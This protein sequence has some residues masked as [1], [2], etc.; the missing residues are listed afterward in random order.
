MRQFSR[1][2]PVGLTALL[3]GAL[4][5]TGC[6]NASENEGDSDAT[7]GSSSST[8]ATFDPTSIAK[9]DAIAALVPAAVAKDGKLVVGSNTEYAPA[10]FVAADGRTPIGYDIDLIKGVAAVL[11][12]QA[13]IQ[14][15][16]FA[17]I[18]PA[19][20]SKYEAGISSFTI[21]AERE[22]SVN[23]I[24][25]FNAG[26]QFSVAKGNPKNI[27]PKNLCGLKVAVETA[28]V[29][30]EGAG[31]LSKA[32]TDAGKKAIEILRYDS[33]ADATT[34]LVGGKAD[35]MYADSPVIAY[36]VEQTKGEIEALGG[37]F[38]SAVQG[39]VVAKSDT[40]LADAISKAIQKMIDDGDYA[41]I[42][43]AWGNAE[44]AITTA[45]INPKVP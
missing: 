8:A 42:L 6:T 9:D 44:G 31:E 22:Q 11:G 13:Q 41:K 10:E 17:A 39:V 28:T 35:V 45:E 18:I 24:S 7:S 21:T 4:T 43:D 19:V 29:E 33:Q 32:C 40:E 15:A 25:I 26:E 34:N 30:D 37:V 1:L 12:L 14:S 27:D 36:A 38:D 16:D 2:L 20:G 5:L 3:A 23:M